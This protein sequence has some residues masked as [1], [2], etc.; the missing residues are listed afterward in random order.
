MIG[1]SSRSYTQG[2]FIVL[3]LRFDWLPFPYPFLPESVHLF[4][5]PLSRSVSGSRRTGPILHR[6]RAKVALGRYFPA[7]IDKTSRVK[8]GLIA[9][10]ILESL[11]SVG[12][13]LIAPSLV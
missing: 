10:T 8:A 13:S 2:M 7:R 1:N 3:S 9:P 12:L 11:D 4:L 6:E 5:T